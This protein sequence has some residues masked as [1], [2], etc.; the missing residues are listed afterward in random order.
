MR[1]MFLPDDQHIVF[2]VSLRLARLP[3]RNC[4]KP[5]V[6]GPQNVQRSFTHM[7][8][9]SIAS[10]VP[11]VIFASSSSLSPAYPVVPNVH[12]CFDV[13]YGAFSA[14]LT[15]SGGGDSSQLVAPLYGWHIVLPARSSLLLPH[16]CQLPFNFAGGR[17]ENNRC[18]TPTAQSG[19]RPGKPS[20]LNYIMQVLPIPINQLL[21]TA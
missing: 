20:T 21:I 1:Q 8:V 5:R 4:T 3:I 13:K 2:M 6:A 11:P 7:P 9:E 10:G 14:R 17:N 15:P 18:K 12:F 16:I 19:I